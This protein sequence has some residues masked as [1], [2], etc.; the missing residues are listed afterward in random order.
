MTGITLRLTIADPVPGMI[1]SLQDQK[2]VPVGPVMATDAPLSFD[3][4]VKLSDDNRLTG[5]FVRREGPERRF[6][7]IAIGGQ[8]GGHT[9]VSRR[10]KIDV[11]QLGA[12]LDQARAGKV[13]AATLPGR[14]KD[15]LPAC[16]TVKPIEPWRAV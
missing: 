11:H 3:V 2:S 14:D 1:Y 15:G 8:A 4:P 12:L 9:T 7:Y 5:P 6:V 16:A 10:A 13:L